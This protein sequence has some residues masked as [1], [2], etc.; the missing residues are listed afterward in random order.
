MARGSFR[1]IIFQLPSHFG[2]QLLHRPGVGIG[3]AQG[4]AETHLILGAHG[5]QLQR[6]IVLAGPAEEHPPGLQRPRRQLLG[7]DAA[8]VGEAHRPIAHK[9]GAQLFLRPKGQQ[10]Q[11]DKPPVCG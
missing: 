6:G 8:Q 4:G 5:S 7:R 3:A 9:H 1:R 11:L 2:Q 10:G